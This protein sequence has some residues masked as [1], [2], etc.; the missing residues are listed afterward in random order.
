MAAT[1]EIHQQQMIPISFGRSIKFPGLVQGR[2]VEWGGRL[3]WLP[4]EIGVK[5]WNIEALS[6]PW[7]AL[8]RIQQRSYYCL[9]GFIIIAAASAA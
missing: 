5:L 2:V 8:A 6:R 4:P 9:S 1:S 3:H 7:F